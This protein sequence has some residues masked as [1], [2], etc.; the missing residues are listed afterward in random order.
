MYA[1]LV[2]E[3]VVF[4]RKSTLVAFA[5]ADWTDIGVSFGAVNVSFVTL[6]AGFAPEGFAGAGMLMTDVW[7][8]VLVL[9]S[10]VAV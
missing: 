5:R 8:G 10:S 9:V 6:E 1:L 3:E 4:A 7:T 2:F